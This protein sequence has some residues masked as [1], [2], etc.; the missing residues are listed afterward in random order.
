MVE[1]HL[2]AIE[3]DADIATLIAQVAGAAGYTPHILCNTENL[4]YGYHLIQPHVIVLDILMPELDGFDVMNFLAQQRSRAKIIIVS[5]SHEYRPMAERIGHAYGLDIAGN[6]GK[7][8]RVA[9]LREMFE[10]LRG[11]LD[12]AMKVTA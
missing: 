5:G 12:N 9:E 3:D 4:T 1:L 7:P 11:D 2:L 6:I 10:R 8:F